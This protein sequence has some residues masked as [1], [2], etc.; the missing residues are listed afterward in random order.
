MNDFSTVQ[1]HVLAAVTQVVGLVVAFVP[2][3]APLQETLIAGGSTVLA[4]A[5]LIAHALRSK[6][7]K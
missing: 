7:V 3:L 2:S 1:A 4:A 6:P 5:V